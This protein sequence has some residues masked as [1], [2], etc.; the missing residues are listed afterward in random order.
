MF[1]GSDIF[2]QPLFYPNY[3]KIGFDLG[4]TLI[5]AKSSDCLRR[6]PV[7]FVKPEMV[8]H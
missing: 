8:T 1:T 3:L 4:K 2:A 7:D 5:S 6:A